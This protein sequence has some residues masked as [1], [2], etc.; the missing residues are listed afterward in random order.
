ML[1]LAKVMPEVTGLCLASWLR[2]YL[3][4]VLVFLTSANRVTVHISAISFHRSADRYRTE[5]NDL[6]GKNLTYSRIP[7][8]RVLQTI[9]STTPDLII[10]THIPHKPPPLS[11]SSP[12][13]LTYK[14]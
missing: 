14:K 7:T 2:G 3:W 13:S 6:T 4:D 9:Q 1:A 5:T 12:T 10:V 8:R 11:L